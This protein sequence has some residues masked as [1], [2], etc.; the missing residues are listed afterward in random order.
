MIKSKQKT[1]IDIV[2]KKKSIIRSVDLI[3]RSTKLNFLF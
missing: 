2:S 3:L 1:I